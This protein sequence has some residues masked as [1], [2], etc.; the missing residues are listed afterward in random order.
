MIQLIQLN[1]QKNNL[2]RKKSK[3]RK[4][5]FWEEDVDLGAGERC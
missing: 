1:H 2:S 5:D 3:K 4:L